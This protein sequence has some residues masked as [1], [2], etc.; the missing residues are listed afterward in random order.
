M[1]LACAKK[2]YRKHQRTAITLSLTLSLILIAATQP[3]IAAQASRNKSSD[4]IVVG[5]DRGGL[6]SRRVAEIL[7]IQADGKRVEI[8]GRV[9]L[10]TC[11]M[12]LG[13]P[14]TCIS[15]T[16]VFGF[17]GPSYYGTP[18]SHRD[19]EYWS[20]VIAKH[21]PEP[22]RSWYMRDGRTRIFS[23]YRIKGRELI[24]MGILQC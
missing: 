4:V 10:S 5:N 22:I 19:F 13:M 15:P 2:S 8:R 24:R 14:Q 7:K 17:H 23:A 18:L 21:Y 20:N 1:P 11:T 6:V 16:T 9:C 12:Y 3:L